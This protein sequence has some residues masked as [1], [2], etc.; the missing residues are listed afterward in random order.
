MRLNAELYLN[1]EISD[2]GDGLVSLDLPNLDSEDPKENSQIWANYVDNTLKSLLSDIPIDEDKLGFVMRERYIDLVR[3]RNGDMPE[4]QSMINEDK[5]FPKMDHFAQKYGEESYKLFEEYTKKIFRPNPED[6][7]KLI[8]LDTDEIIDLEKLVNNSDTSTQELRNAKAMLGLLIQQYYMD[9]ELLLDEEKVEDL[10]IQAI[11]RINNYKNDKGENEHRPNTLIALNGQ[12]LAG[13]GTTMELLG[14][15]SPVETGTAGI[16]GAGPNHEHWS[17]S[18]KYTQLSRDEGLIPPDKIV[19]TMLMLELAK[20]RD[21]MDKLDKQ[22]DPIVLSGFPRSTNQAEQLDGI[23]GIKAVYLDMS[24]SE[25]ARRT[26][27]RIVETL[28]ANS[29][30]TQIRGDDA[31]SLYFTDSNGQQLSGIEII[32]KIKGAVDSVRI[33]NSDNMSNFELGSNIISQSADLQN[34]MEN[35]QLSEKA[36]WHTF[37]KTKKQIASALEKVGVNQQEILVD[38]KSPKQVADEVRNLI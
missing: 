25:N 19:T 34:I 22:N 10:R 9:V 8:A 33:G 12:V 20:R 18:S 16:L 29:E 2:E 32:E 37:N 31:S 1:M 30:A 5:P 11:E 26:I 24:A 14:L 38:G 27:R 23:D 4:N 3:D 7:K 36:R 28:G 35:A 13:K 6:D 17:G 21:E 15:E